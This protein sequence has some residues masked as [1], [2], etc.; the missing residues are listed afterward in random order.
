MTENQNVIKKAGAVF[1]SH[2]PGVA[3]SRSARP[4]VP[5]PRGAAQQSGQLCLTR[6]T[7]NKLQ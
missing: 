6:S 3:A 1:K 5:A 2:G 4:S 7:R